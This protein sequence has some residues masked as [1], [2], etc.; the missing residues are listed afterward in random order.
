MYKYDWPTGL[1][2]AMT[3]LFY[4][5]VVAWPPDGGVTG[6]TIVTGNTETDRH[7]E[8]RREGDRLFG[9]NIR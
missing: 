2:S 5:R 7:R 1:I 4:E 3:M 9:A 6:H 8:G